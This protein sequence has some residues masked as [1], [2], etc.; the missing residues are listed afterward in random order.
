MEMIKATNIHYSYPD[1][2]KALQGIDFY[3]NKGEMVALL[4][5]NGCGKTTFFQ[6][7][8][9][10][11]KPQEG[12]IFLKG[13][14][15]KRKKVEEIC[16]TVGLVF[17]DPNDQLFAATVYEDVSYGPVNLGL[18]K[19]EIKTRVSQA[20]ELMNIADLAQ[21][22]INT[23]SFG[24]K[25]KVAIAGILAL[26]PEV[27]VL[28]EPTA[29]LDPRGTTQLMKILKEVQVKTGA[30]IVI[31]THQ[32]ELV[33]L[34]CQRVYVLQ[35][36]RVVLEGSPE[37]VFNQQKVL[38]E[39]NLRLPPVAHLFEIL[40]LKTGMEMPSLPLTVGQGYHFLSDF[41]QHRGKRL[42]KGYTTGS[43]A[44]AAAQ[45]A[46]QMLFTERMLEKVQIDT[47]SG[48]KLV[49]E[50]KDIVLNNKEAACSVIKDGGDD[51]DITT[52]LSIYAIA[53]EIPEGI[54]IKGGEGVGTV[55][56]PGLQIKVGEPAINPVP[57]EM[58]RS[59][60]AK[61]L[62]PNKGVEITISV[63]GGKEAARKTLNPRL[64]IIDGISILGT[65]GI[66]E[67]M[68]EEAFKTSLVP[69]IAMAKAHGYKSIVLTPGRIG[70]KAAVETYGLP[71][72]AVIQMSNFTGFMLEECERLGIEKVLLFGHIGKLVKVAAGIFH[73][74][75]KVAD[76]RL[77]TLAAYAGTIG[78]TPAVISEL[79]Q[80]VTVE[81]ALDIIKQNG[82][83]A[84]YKILA[85]QASKRAKEHVYGELEVGTVMTSLTGE[86]LAKDG[87]ADEIGSELGWTI[88]SI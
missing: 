25:K 55:T 6:H 54:V 32:V 14:N 70:Q 76:A 62:P 59:E 50:L 53:R 77:E 33:P 83:T 16:K 38:R 80:A 11:L 74:H 13:E 24:Q 56:K 30:S 72:E 66:V 75:S 39:A 86:I 5:A 85:E 67:P 26:K 51:P 21:R 7:I 81:G 31:S 34:Y 20:L 35:K 78:A 65:S 42:R 88:K 23:L 10:L 63:P 36:G 18:S 73:T 47:P 48:V 79:L 82:L 22:S 61:V 17:Q 60:V 12:E 29:G 46:T 37:E 84:V 45:G 71:Q 15:F 2:F 28:D 4:G 87:Y 27:L 40:K 9:G 19:T 1:G 3:L 8:N 69:Q 57:L 44:A 49:L 52:G 68:S 64:G 58:I 41:K 43:C